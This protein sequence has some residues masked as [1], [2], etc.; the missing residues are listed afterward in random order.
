MERKLAAL[1]AGPERGAVVEV[2]AH[3]LGSEL[4]HSLRRPLGARQGANVPAL[5]SEALYESASDEARSSGYERPGQRFWR[6]S[7]HCQPLHGLCETSLTLALPLLSRVM[8]KLVHA[9]LFVLFV[10]MKFPRGFA[11]E[12]R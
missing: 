6:P 7:P 12:T 4:P 11:V 2:A 1:G 8:R 10:S 3:R 9:V 5:R